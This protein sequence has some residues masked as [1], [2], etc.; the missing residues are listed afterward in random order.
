MHV[1]LQLHS[2]GFS[3]GCASIWGG[4]AGCL[5][6]RAGLSAVLGVFLILPSLSRFIF[7]FFHPSISLEKE[8]VARFNRFCSTAR[9]GEEV[10]VFSTF[11]SH[12]PRVDS[13]R[14]CALRVVLA[15]L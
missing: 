5:D 11:P 14:L 6:G 1:W 7:C 9:R 8:R 4:R 10:F 15:A 2:V 13:Q 3:S 12:K